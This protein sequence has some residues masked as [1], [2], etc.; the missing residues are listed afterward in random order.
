MSDA[1]AEGMNVHNIEY[2]AEL[3]RKGIHLTSLSIPVIY[4]FIERELAL[5]ILVPITFAFL[6]VDLL[7][8]YHAPTARLF[9]TLFGFMLRKHEQDGNNKRLNGATNVLIAATLCIILFPK[10]IVI[11]AFTI[12]IVSDTFAALIGRKFGRRK[13]LQKSVEGSLAF[14]IF[15]LVVVAVTP[16]VEYAATEYLIGAIASVVGTVVEAGS[17]KIDDNLSIPFSVGIVMWGLYM[18]LYPSVNLFNYTLP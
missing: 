12:L 11:T 4:Y 15:S 9:Y 8:Y 10:L 1:M 2:K 13:F 17:W 5:S 6:V 3:V 7:R 18:L 14:F 16:K